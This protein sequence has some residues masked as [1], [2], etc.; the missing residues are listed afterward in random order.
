MHKAFSK[1]LR[2]FTLIELLVVIAI[3]GIL[4]SVVL[5]SLNSARSRGQDA[6]VKAN[7]NGIRTQAELIYDEATPPSYALVCDTN[8]APIVDALDAAASAGGGAY[9]CESDDD[10]WV[11]TAPLR[12]TGQGHWCV[13]YTGI[14]ATTTGAAADGDEECSD[15]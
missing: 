15:I 7:L 13:D 11:A 12:E 8:T 5:V 14:S 6:A 9:G 3:I 1:G 10:F 4:A 2:G